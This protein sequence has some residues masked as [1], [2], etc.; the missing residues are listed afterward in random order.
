MV[1]D[2]LTKIIDDVYIGRIS[3]HWAG[4][5]VLAN[6]VAARYDAEQAM[7]RERMLVTQYA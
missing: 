6:A 7:I 4:D 1:S 2:L 3:G 5:S